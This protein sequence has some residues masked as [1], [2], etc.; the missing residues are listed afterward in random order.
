MMTIKKTNTMGRMFLAIA[1][2]TAGFTLPATSA[3][4][5]AWEQQVAKVVMSNQAYPRSAQVR[6]E[7]GKAMVKVSIAGDG[8]ITAVE[9]VESSGSSVLDREATKTFEKIGKLPA[10]P[11]SS[12]RDVVFP[13]VWSLN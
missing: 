11:G 10:P 9:L 8:A 4:A 13:L 2:A 1:F 6:N 5:N 7:E 12:A 3:L